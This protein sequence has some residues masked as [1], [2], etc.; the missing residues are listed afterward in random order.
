VE[1]YAALI[2]E[3]VRAKPAASKG[4]YIKGITLTS[5]MGPGIHV[6]AARTRGIVEELEEEPAAATA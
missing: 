6:D 3:I 2:D 1:N 5:T 4:R